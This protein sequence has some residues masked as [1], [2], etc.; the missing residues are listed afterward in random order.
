[1][2]RVGGSEL[3]E[4]QKITGLKCLT[5]KKNINYERCEAKIIYNEQ[6][7]TITRGGKQ[8]RLPD[9][10]TVWKPWQEKRKQMKFSLRSSQMLREKKLAGLC[11]VSHLI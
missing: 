11:A 1:M 6:I 8:Y 10:E 5:T 4:T 2:V 9:L 7:K 3:R